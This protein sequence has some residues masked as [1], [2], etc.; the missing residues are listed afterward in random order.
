MGSEISIFDK[1]H[2]SSPWSHDKISVKLGS[3]TG[4]NKYT[5]LGGVEKSIVYKSG[6]V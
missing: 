2:V 6:R 3:Y 5:N 1:L 4:M